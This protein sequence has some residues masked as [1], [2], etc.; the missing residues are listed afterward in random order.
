VSVA[1]LAVAV[2]RKDLR[3]LSALAVP[4]GVLVFAVLAYAA[5]Q[6]AGWFR[7]YITAVPLLVM[8]GGT[9]LAC[10]LKGP[11][12]NVSRP[13]PGRIHRLRVW[14]TRA[15]AAG[16]VIVLVAPSLPSTAWAMFGNT[17]V[18]GEEHLHLDF[19]TRP[20]PHDVGQQGE[21]YRWFST[22]TMAQAFD[23]MHLPD[24]AILIDNFTPCV[25]YIILNSKHP[26]QFV[27]PNDEDFLKDLQDPLTF[28]VQYLVAPPH[29]GYGALDAVNRAHVNLYIPG[30]DI[31]TEVRHWS[32]PG[33]PRL[34]LFKVN[35]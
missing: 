7:Y 3:V 33:C 4:G 20:K 31:A 6:T 28:H 15:A 9:L 27:I 13:A 29:G 30:A 16:L 25:P 2:R 17:Q 21:K 14:T 35:Q 1:A 34:T 12:A 19:I 5:G 26:R 24:G 22:R 32:L 18:A 23:A 8:A 11:R 10:L